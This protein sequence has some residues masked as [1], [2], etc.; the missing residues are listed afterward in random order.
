MLCV[1]CVWSCFFPSIPFVVGSNPIL[2][3]SMSRLNTAAVTPPRLFRPRFPGGGRGKTLRNC[4]NF[5]ICPR[6][7]YCT[8]RNSSWL[9][10]HTHARSAI[11]S[12]T[13]CFSEG[14]SFR[15]HPR[16][17]YCAC[18][19]FYVAHHV[20]PIF[21]PPRPSGTQQNSPRGGVP[22]LEVGVGTILGGFKNWGRL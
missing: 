15:N 1:L 13:F 18:S 4:P 7:L 19:L 17:L 22:V 2:A 8:C 11:L 10:T 16:V 12:I 5:G 21:S 9:H 6:F 14:K 3:L 20:T